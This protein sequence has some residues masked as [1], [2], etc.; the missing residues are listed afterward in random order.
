MTT[1]IFPVLV[2]G[3][4]EIYQT[5]LANQ[6]SSLMIGGN[7]LLSALAVAKKAQCSLVSGV[8]LD[9]YDNLLQLKIPNL[10]LSGLKFYPEQKSFFY[11][12]VLDENGSETSGTPEFNCHR[13]FLDTT[14]N[15][16][17]TCNILHCS[18]TDPDF[19][20][21]NLSNIDYQILSVTTIGYFLE[22]KPES[23]VKLMQKADIIFL[24]LDE[25]ES[26]KK[27]MGLSNKLII[28]TKGANGLDVYSQNQKY[29]FETKEVQT[30]NTVNAGD[31]LAGSFLANLIERNLISKQDILAL[32]QAELAQ[33]IS[34]SQTETQKLL[35][36]DPYYRTLL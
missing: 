1:N 30:K 34:N 24:N 6:D 27:E 29:S 25:F 20:L 26:L 13:Q 32:E 16:F 2:L 21:N 15:D 7:G 31:V 3:T 28:I 36:Q 10:D 19:Y 12:S 23:V 8:G 14:F 18:G 4:T 11:K 5:Q 33:I 9:I 17:L 35:Q 22:K